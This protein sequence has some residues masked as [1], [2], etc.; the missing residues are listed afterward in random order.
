M[1]YGAKGYTGLGPSGCAGR[2][3]S[4][5]PGRKFRAPEVLGRVRPKPK[6]GTVAAGLASGGRKFRTGPEV[7]GGG[8]SGQVPG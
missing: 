6:V 3:G 8:S 7:P 2:A 5:G 4:S 1:V